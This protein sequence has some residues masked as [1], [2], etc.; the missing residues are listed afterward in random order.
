[1]ELKCPVCAST[2]IEKQSVG[3]SAKTWRCTDCQHS[4]MKKNFVLLTATITE[5]SRF[6]QLR[7][8][9]PKAEMGDYEND[10]Q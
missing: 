4:D 5:F 7:I 10:E 9:D 3:R 6:N 2:N 8:H 1:M